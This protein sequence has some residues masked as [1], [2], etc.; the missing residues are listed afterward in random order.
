MNTQDPGLAMPML[1]LKWDIKDKNVLYTPAK[2]EGTHHSLAY[3]QFARPLYT[4]S[5]FMYPLGCVRSGCVA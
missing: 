2:T 4:H 5:Q 1:I 3:E